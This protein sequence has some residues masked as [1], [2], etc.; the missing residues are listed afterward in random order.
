[1]INWDQRDKR[2]HAFY[3]AVIAVVAGHFTGYGVGLALSLL[4]GA[5]KE[6]YDWKSGTGTPSWLDFAADVVGAVAGAILLAVTGTKFIDMDGIIGA[7][8]WIGGFF[9]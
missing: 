4:I 8:S 2:L 6:L 3:S 9:S 7:I 5:A 1:M